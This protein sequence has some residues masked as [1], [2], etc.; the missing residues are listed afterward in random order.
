MSKLV[1]PTVPQY[2]VIIENFHG[3]D[4]SIFHNVYKGAIN[5]IAD[6]IKKNA[7]DKSDSVRYE[8]NINT[9]VAFVG[10]R[11][12]GKSSA[13][14]SFAN[15]LE[16]DNKKTDWIDNPD[17]KKTIASTR[18]HCLPVIDASQLSEKETVLGRIAAAM[19]T[20]Y[21]K[22]YRSK[23]SAEQKQDFI[24]KAK[25]VT[26]LAVLHRTGEW[27]KT[28]DGLLSDTERISNMSASISQLIKS[29]LKMSRDQSDDY[30]AMNHYLVVSIDDL[31]MGVGNSYAIMEEIRKFLF[32][33]NVIVLITLDEKLLDSVL[34]STFSGA[35]NKTD[36]N[37]TSVQMGA[38]NLIIS[39]SNG[40]LIPSLSYRYIEK[41]FPSDR[42][43]HM[44]VLSLN[45]LKEICAENFLGNADG[46]HS[47]RKYGLDCDDMSVLNGV[48]HLIWRKT[49]L[50]SVCDKDGDHLIV[51]RN[52]RSL[53][54]MVI[55]LRSLKDVAYKEENG[56]IKVHCYKDF[57]GNDGS[58]LR[59]VLDNNLRAFSQYLID[60]ISSYSRPELSEENST[61]ATVLRDLIRVLPNVQ[62]RRINVQI[63]GTILNH[64]RS[65]ADQGVTTFYH[66]IF[67]KVMPHMSEST[68]NCNDDLIDAV[69]E[70]PDSISSGDVIYVLG[71]LDTRSYCEY[72]RY[73]VEVI[74]T[75][76]SI[77][78]TQELYV[79]G[80]SGTSTNIISSNKYFTESFR[81]TVG[82]FIINPNNASFCNYSDAKTSKKVKLTGTDWYMY[83]DVVDQLGGELCKLICVNRCTDFP[84][85]GF[86]VPTSS[87]DPYYKSQNIDIV[88]AL[89]N[90][91][92]IFT[93]TLDISVLQNKIKSGDDKHIN[94]RIDDSLKGISTECDPNRGEDNE[95]YI[96]M[97]FYSL[98]Y[99]YRFY[100]YLH[101]ATDAQQAPSLL[102]AIRHIF[103]NKLN[104]PGE[105]STPTNAL[106]KRIQEYLPK[107]F[108]ENVIENPMIRLTIII[109]TAIECRSLYDKLKIV[110]DTLRK[111]KDGI[112][113]VT[114]TRKELY[115]EVYSCYVQQNDVID[116]QSV[117]RIFK[118]LLD[119]IGNSN[120]G[121]DPIIQVDEVSNIQELIVETINKLS[122]LIKPDVNDDGK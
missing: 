28:G 74:R 15:Y 76:W 7:N 72:I 19:F 51:P 47:W 118:T 77:R 98:D 109:E 81:Q 108:V 2:G 96:A 53:C 24:K 102:Q 83:K 121:K 3:N 32:I 49:M 87:S 41:L 20:Q 45:Q 23:V 8:E 35:L 97:P 34:Q 70:H 5:N 52:L 103:T 113:G 36:S 13:M 55:F 73:L 92:S 68:A 39:G 56:A 63:V 104:S 46:N 78:M 86:R 67:K 88:E 114:T 4:R 65:Y 30:S 27:F 57:I 106:S 50:I 62:L 25:E 115:S 116:D 79:S 100:Q 110:I 90:P 101:A 89:L 61:L 33:K 17:T 64:V 107:E 6:I 69:A 94:N 82:G 22:E 59:D 1:I 105:T 48:L 21:N 26:E 91:M 120:S 85:M 112:V 43:H 37:I 111:I 58:G 16:K 60:N 84:C 71:K 14:G 18:F 31:D 117:D 29:F 66:D 40:P 9:I 93:N 11:G 10:G 54:N 44:P 119:K 38:A 75:L 80:F 122:E 42:Q 95:F 99:I 12:T